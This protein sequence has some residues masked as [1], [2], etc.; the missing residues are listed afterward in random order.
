MNVWTF[1]TPTAPTDTSVE[2]ELDVEDYTNIYLD[3][4]DGR[5]T[6]PIT[7]SVAA[8]KGQYFFKDINF[9]KVSNFT[10]VLGDHT[11]GRMPSQMGMFIK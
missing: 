2:V 9:L 4:G 6:I 11:Y 5:T 8:F 3:P 7:K 10:N 1:L